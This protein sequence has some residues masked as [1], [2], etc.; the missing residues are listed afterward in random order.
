[1]KCSL[2]HKWHF[3]T[4]NAMFKNTVTNADTNKDEKLL[5]TKSQSECN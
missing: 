4:E 2:D 5:N 3:E 1:M